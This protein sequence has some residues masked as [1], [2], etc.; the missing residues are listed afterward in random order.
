MFKWVTQELFDE[1]LEVLC[2]QKTGAELLQIPGVYEALSEYL[3]N[4]VLEVLCDYNDRD[5]HTGEKL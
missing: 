5:R 2:D 1:Q 3:N 4:E